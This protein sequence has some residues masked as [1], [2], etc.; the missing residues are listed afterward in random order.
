MDVL[1]ALED[2]GIDEEHAAEVGIRLFKITMPW[3]LERESARHFAEGLDEILVVEENA[4]QL[5]A[6]R[7]HWPGFEPCYRMYAQATLGVFGL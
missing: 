7:L 6:E 3:P 4:P 1:Q 2:L 5:M